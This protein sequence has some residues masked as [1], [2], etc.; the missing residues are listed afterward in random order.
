M[1][2]VNLR[3][4]AVKKL[5]SFFIAATVLLTSF[6]GFATDR[7]TLYPGFSQIT[8]S[9]AFQ[10]F[11]RRPVS[12]FSKILYLIDRFSEA[13]IEIVYD[14]VTYKAVFATTVARW[15]LA[16][17]Y[18]K[19]SPEA[20]VNQWCNR[21]INNKLIYVKLPD[22]KFRL[23]REI[24]LKELQDLEEVMREHQT[25]SASVAAK[26]VDAASTAPTVATATAGLNKSFSAKAQDLA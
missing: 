4:F 26:A 11:S 25:A 19:Q 1:M 16:R 13:N 24:L 21:S 12:D 18:K 8:E 2:V 7:I 6:N 15:F 9:K 23:S 22:G 20:W 17:N 10:K 3:R 14:E 5:A